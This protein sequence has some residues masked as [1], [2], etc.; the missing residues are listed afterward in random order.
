MTMAVSTQVNPVATRLAV[1]TAL[2]A[3]AQHNLFGAPCVLY[4][5]EADNTG[6]AGAPC[7]VKLYNAASAVPGTLDPHV[8]LM[9]PPAAKR[10]FA[11][12][13][14]LAFGVGL[15]C[16]CVTSP[17]TPGTTAP[18]SAVPVRLLASV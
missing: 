13:E 15:S 12:P 10:S 16:C 2:G 4:L 17:G 9:V 14:G 1:D 3:T 11:I 7:Y 18:T 8:V 6:N 5:V